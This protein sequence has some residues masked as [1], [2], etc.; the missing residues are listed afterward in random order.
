MLPLTSDII[1][2]LVL[3]TGNSCRSQMAE[4]FLGRYPH[5]VA[6]SAGTQPAERVHPD[7]IRVMA[8]IGI[9]IGSSTPKHV[10]QFLGESFDLVLTVCDS[11]NEAC[12]VFTGS[13]AK[14]FHHSFEDPAGKDI[15]TFRKVR[16]QIALFTGN[17]INT[18]KTNN[19]VGDHE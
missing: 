15:E 14:R 8:E 16:D 9:D 19:Q 11:A 18:M 3:C 6:F 10:G 4:G 2:V 12:P 5:V 13:V 7:A 1:R 17:L